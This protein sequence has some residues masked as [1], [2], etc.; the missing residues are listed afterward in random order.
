MMNPTSVNSSHR[1]SQSQNQHRRSY[2]YEKSDLWCDG[3]M[4]ER[5]NSSSPPTNVI[6]TSGG[7]RDTATTSG[8]PHCSTSMPSTSAS[9][10][11]STDPTRGRQRLVQ[12][13]LND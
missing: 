13:D 5:V 8:G 10:S 7:D 2:G 11:S 1:L 3:L 6:S 9:A 12:I 4:M